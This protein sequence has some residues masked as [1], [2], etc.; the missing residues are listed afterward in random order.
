MTNS[1]RK[2]GTIQKT[3]NHI[4]SCIKL[5]TAVKLL[6]HQKLLE[7]VKTPNK[8]KKRQNENLN[9]EP[10]PYFLRSKNKSS[11]NNYKNQIKEKDFKNSKK[12][13]TN[14]FSIEKCKLLGKKTKR[15]LYVPENGKTTFNKNIENKNKNQNKDVISKKSKVNNDDTYKKN[16]KELLDNMCINRSPKRF[17]SPKTEIPKNIKQKTNFNSPKKLIHTK[18]FLSPNRVFRNTIDHFQTFNNNK[19]RLIL[20]KYQNNN[21]KKEQKMNFFNNQTSSYDKNSKKIDNNSNEKELTKNLTNKSNGK[22]N[23]QNNNLNMNLTDTT[24]KQKD[25][26]FCKPISKNNSKNV[27]NFQNSKQ[28]NNDNKYQ[29]K[30]LRK[31]CYA[32]FKN[33]EFELSKNT[34]SP[35]IEKE[36]INKKNNN[37]IYK[38]EI[39]NKKYYDLK[40]ITNIDLQ[41]GDMTQCIQDTDNF[42]L[43]NINVDLPIIKTQPQDPFNSFVTAKMYEEIFPENQENVIDLKCNTFKKMEEKD[44]IE[45]NEKMLLSANGYILRNKEK[46]PINFEL[47]NNNI[48]EEIVLKDFDNEN[49]KDLVCQC[50]LQSVKQIFPKTLDLFGKKFEFKLS[51]KCEGQLIKISLEGKPNNIN[52]NN[53]LTVKKEKSLN[54]GKN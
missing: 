23:I 53:E 25:D 11:K 2:S 37:S 7:K 1:T 48:K 34:V 26:K 4:E 33:V 28:N 40:N 50:A 41:L 14:I 54:G 39:E 24:S 51:T 10:S 21:T 44:E 30:I 22:K 9:Y 12:E 3:K 13:E 36:F 8:I 20:N 5:N 45:N 15:D 47:D 49:Y 38:N 6:D 43:F 29:R 27:G 52:K 35:K 31:K 46:I 42:S 19:N 32:V 16:I 17:R 18:E